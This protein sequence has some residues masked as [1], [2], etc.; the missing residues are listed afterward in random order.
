M[1]SAPVIPRNL[2]QKSAQASDTNATTKNDDNVASSSTT[3]EMTHNDELTCGG[4]TKSE[5]AAMETNKSS[6]RPKKRVNEGRLEIESALLEPRPKRTRKKATKRTAK[7]QKTAENIA[8][9]KQEK[10]AAVVSSKV[11]TP[12]AVLS[13][14]PSSTT[15]LVSSS[16]RRLDQYNSSDDDHC[17][18]RKLEGPFDASKFT[19]GI[20]TY[21][22]ASE[23]KVGEVPAYVTD[24]F[25]RL[26]DAEV[27]AS[28]V[29]SKCVADTFETWNKVLYNR[30]SH[31][32]I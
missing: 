30:F 18:P 11:Q 27:S 20:A 10:K 12:D 5:V 21:D 13:V 24:I 23:G 8:P 3:E 15:A 25:Q 26:F 6:S 31:Q 28:I 29:K 14:L 9:P 1:E 19:T 32:S 4:L 16:H 17:L 7:K 2:D 22:R